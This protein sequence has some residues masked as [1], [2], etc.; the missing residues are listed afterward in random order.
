M[1]E[2]S[3]SPEDRRLRFILAQTMWRVQF[4]EDLPSDTEERKAAWE[5]VKTAEL[6]KA[7]RMIRM[8]DNRGVTLSV[9][10]AAD[11]ADAP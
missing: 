3:K 6:Q 7:A 8:L 1:S 10:E 4:G 11:A 9:R 5:Q 2:N